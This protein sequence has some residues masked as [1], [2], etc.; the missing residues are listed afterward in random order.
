MTS[1]GINQDHSGPMCSVTAPGVHGV[2]AAMTHG[3]MAALASP[4]YPVHGWTVFG[5]EK[6]GAWANRQPTPMAWCVMAPSRAAASSQQYDHHEKPAFA[7]HL[8]HVAG[9][10]PVG[11]TN[12]AILDKIEWLR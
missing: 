6:L 2:T 12:G 4:P 5:F 8:L 7:C 10:C 1:D 9:G 11:L 3:P